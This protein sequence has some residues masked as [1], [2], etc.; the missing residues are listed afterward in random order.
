M[1]TILRSWS[2]RYQWLYDTVSWFSTLPVGGIDR[3]HQLPLSGLSLGAEAEVLD[4]C[5]GSGQ[6]TAYLTQRY[7]SVTGLD[8]SPLSIKR[9]QANVP[10]ATYVE[11]W[12]EAMP[13]EDQRFDLVHSS[14]ALH[15]MKP[16][17]L[18]QILQEIC[19]VLK[20]GGIFACIDLHQ[21]TNPLLVPGLYAFMLLFETETAW[22]LVRSDL[23]ETVADHG[24]VIQQHTYHGGGSLQVIQASK[25]S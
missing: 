9:A 25:P 12:A 17:Q 8:A 5:C 15:E 18:S 13:F 24:L 14:V 3:F 6:A 22:Q 1:A 16:K 23:P 19:R 21:P 4:L 2:Y 7:R 11:G 10:A 20:P